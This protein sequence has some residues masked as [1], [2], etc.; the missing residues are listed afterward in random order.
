MCSVGSYLHG[1]DVSGKTVNGRK[2][3]K[4]VEITFEVG[5]RFIRP[6]LTTVEPR[7]MQ[8]CRGS[9]VQDAHTLITSISTNMRRN[10]IICT[11]IF[12]I[13]LS[14]IQSF[15]RIEIKPLFIQ[16][17]PKIVDCC[18]WYACFYIH[19]LICSISTNMRLNK[20]IHITIFI[21]YFLSY[22]VVYS[23]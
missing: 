23:D 20:I 6:I 7:L 14:A 19:T 21:F 4:V 1:I 15:T 5:I 9:C 8:C 10:K 22:P 18:V 11:T 12:I 17:W 2:V 3:W 13:I 16:L